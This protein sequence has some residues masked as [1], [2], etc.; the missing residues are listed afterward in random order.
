MLTGSKGTIWIVFAYSMQPSWSK[1]DGTVIIWFQ[2]L[3]EYDLIRAYTEDFVTGQILGVSDS[4][5]SLSKPH[6]LM[7]N[8][9]EMH[10]CTSI[11]LT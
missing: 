9:I 1:L 4:H 10:L 2:P 3:R 5:T 11:P 8:V 6:I 7:M